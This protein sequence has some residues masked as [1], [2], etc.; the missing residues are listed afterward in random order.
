MSV[1]LWKTVLNLAKVAAVLVL[2]GS[3]LLFWGHSREMGTAWSAPDFSPPILPSTGVVA[4]TKDL[5]L[6]LGRF[7]KER[8]PVEPVKKEE[9]KE[10]I[11]HALARLGE[12]VGA[13]VIYPPY[14]EGDFVPAINFKWKM[15]PA[16]T[17]GDYR[18]IRL[19][20]A[21]IERVADGPTGAVPLQYQFIGCEP[22]PEKPG[23]TFF[24]FDMKCDG[25]DIQKV[26]WK[27]EEEKAKTSEPAPVAAGGVNTDKMYV[28]PRS[29][30]TRPEKPAE[31][32][33]PVAPAPLPP[34][35][36][37]V[38]EPPSG[39]FFEDEGGVL[40]PTREAVDYLER[41]YEK[42][43]EET[44]TETYRDR[45]VRGIRIV[46]ISSSSIANQFGIRKD[47]VV[48][49]INKT[50]VS[51][52]SEAVNVVKSELKKKVT[53]ITVKLLRAGREVEKTYDTRDPA[54]R[55]AAKGLRNR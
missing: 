32:V 6:T 26:H 22:D 50:P 34:P 49:S 54:T 11:L 38:Q 12:I 3:G 15:K 36:E 24:V 55:R 2:V 35:V 5:S 4:Q 45:D 16:G 30:P 39:T 33:Q 53:L 44:R 47:D 10:E 23:F 52:Q 42:I 20:E 19:G 43:L 48:I 8:G 14:G 21:L 17:T 40:L 51:T 9:P 29:G 25:T 28:G 13:I 18:T 7:Q 41:N 46:G 37:V 1:A 27:V 31:Q